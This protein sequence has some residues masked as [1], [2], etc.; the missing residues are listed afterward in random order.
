LKIAEAYSG[1]DLLKY[2]PI[3]RFRQPDITVDFPSWFR[4]W[5]ESPRRA[6]EIYLTSRPEPA[7][8]DMQRSVRRALLESEIRQGW[9]TITADPLSLRWLGTALQIDL[10]AERLIAAE[11]G[12]ERIGVEIKSFIGASAMADLESALGQFVL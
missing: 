10:G 6:A 3:P 4:H 2:L 12:E 7:R 9:G 5:K 11:R 1:H 8:A